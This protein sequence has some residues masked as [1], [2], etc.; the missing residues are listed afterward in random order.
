MIKS[1]EEVA[2]IE[3][4][5]HHTETALAAALDV[6]RESVIRGDEVIWKGRP[7]TS[8]DLKKVVNVSLMENDCIAQH[9]IIACGDRG[10]TRTTRARA[11]S[12]PIKA[13]SSTSSRAPRPPIISP[14]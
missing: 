1:A 6:L 3:E 12:G 8:E 2:A 14:T 13:S 11:P 5:Q 9:T 7:L 4:A 10:W